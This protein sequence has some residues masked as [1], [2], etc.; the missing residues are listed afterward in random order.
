MPEWTTIEEISRFFQ[1]EGY[2]QNY[3]AKQRPRFAAILGG[4]AIAT[5]AL[6]PIVPEIYQKSVETGAN[7]G[8]LAL[9]LYIAFERLFDAKVVEI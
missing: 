8:V 9:S 4:L 2:H 3:W 7:A 1:A 5:G 6:D